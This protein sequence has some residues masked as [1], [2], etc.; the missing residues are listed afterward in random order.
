MVLS[1]KKLKKKLR[2]LVAE[3]QSQVE[4]E[5]AGK[6]VNEELQTIKEILKSNFK[7]RPKR[8]RPSNDQEKVP[9]T[10]EEEKDATS[11]SGDVKEQ[12]KSKKRK[13]DGGAAAVPVDGEDKKSEGKKRKERK[14][15]RWKKGEES[16]KSGGEEQGSSIAPDNEK[17][18]AEPNNVEQSEE[19]TKV[20]VGGI[21]YYW[22][23]DDIRTYFDGCGIVTDMDCMTFPE[24]GKFRGITILTFKTE[25][26]AKKALALDGA[27]MDGFYL[28]IQPYKSNRH[29]KTDFA[30]EIIEGYN[31]I[32]IG[33]LSW[34]ITEDD[35]RNLFSDCKIS[36]IRFGT[37][38]VTGDF[39][40][41][42]HADFDNGAS[43]NIALKLDQTVVCGRPVRIRCAVPAKEVEKKTSLKPVMKKDE[44]KQIGESAKKKR[45][46]CYVCG[47]PGH[48]SSS[49]PKNV[50]SPGIEK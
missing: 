28:K 44:S 30:P 36:S 43:V 3:S 40:G 12:N 8:K 16:V 21:P 42:A 7:K 11:Q 13:R 18:T 46:T 22:S 33:N 38:K 25:D 19:N 27:D 15:P 49:C 48:L 17:G 23:E 31:R 14:K 9:F 37:D 34:D 50:A 35:L 39:K 24:S 29:H 2:H 41:Y 26:A 45:R 6:G 32:Y 5:G 4:S 47:V 1:K 10:E 20:Y